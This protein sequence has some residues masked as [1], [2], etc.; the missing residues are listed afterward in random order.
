TPAPRP[1]PAPP[2][3]PG[4]AAPPNT[5]PASPTNTPP[6]PPTSP[7]TTAEPSTASP[8][9][10]TADHARPSAGTPPPRPTLASRKR[11]NDR[12]RPH[13]SSRIPELL[14]EEVH[15]QDVVPGAVGAAFGAA[16]DA[17]GAEADLGVRTDRGGVVGGGIDREAVVAVVVDQVPRQRPDRVG[18]D[19]APV[20]GGIDVDV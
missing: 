13:L 4:S 7:A 2:A 18:T 17:D 3:A 14:G 8:Q 16:L 10:S 9:S 20:H 11:R 19:A 15:E 5:P 1:P 6:K 12:R